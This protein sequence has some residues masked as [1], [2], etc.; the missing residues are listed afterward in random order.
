MNTTLW[1]GAH[2]G[3]SFKAG[4]AHVGQCWTSDCGAAEA[5]AGYGNSRSLWGADVDMSSLVVETVEGYDYESDRAPGDS[6]ESLA[7][8]RSMG[9]DVVVYQDCDVKGREHDCVRLISD[10]AVEMFSAAMTEY[11]F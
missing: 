2:G 7:S 8:L 4:A 1:H 11:E 5:Y 9:V 6:A 10:R 3:N